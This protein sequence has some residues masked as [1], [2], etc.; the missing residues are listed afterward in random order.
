MAKTAT[1]LLNELANKDLVPGEV[2]ASLRAQVAKAARPVPPQQITKLLVEKGHLTAA[3]AQKLLGAA[4]ASASPKAATATATKPAPKA[5]PQPAPAAAATQPIADDLTALDGLEPLESLDSLEPLA[6]LDALDE[7]APAAAAPAPVSAESLDSLGDADL[8]GSVGGPDPLAA[9]AAASLQKPA[10]QKP[11]KPAAAP[12][13]P[14][15]TALLSL[16]G[17]ALLGVLAA[18]AFAFM[19]RANGDAEFQAAEGEYSAKSYAT[20]AEQYAVLLEKYPQHPQAGLARVH[21]GLAKMHAAAG[22]SNWPQLLPVAK[23]VLTEI[24]AQPQLAEAQAEVA[25]LVSNLAIGLAEQAAAGKTPEQIAAA[26]E[27]L[28]L[29]D[30]GRYVPGNHRP[31]QKLAAA[32]ESLAVAEYQLA[33]VGKLQKSLAA[34]K[35]AVTAKKL[36]EAQAVRE[37]LL[38][39]YPE[40]DRGPALSELG[41]E[42]AAAA[43]TAIQKAELPGQPEAAEGPAPTVALAAGT[44]PIFLAVAGGQLWALDAAKGTLRWRRPVGGFSGQPIRT[45]TEPDADVIVIDAAHSEVVRLA[46]ANGAPRWRRA[47]AGLLAAAPQIAGSQ[48]VLAAA[49]GRVLAL[50]AASGN[51]RAAVQLPVA[52]RAAPLVQ[53]GQLIV[54]G[55]SLY[56]FTLNVSDLSPQ[57]AAYLGHASASATVS[58]IALPQH[59]LVIENRGVG[60]AVLHVLDGAGNS[61]VQELAVGG[62]VTAPP[63]VIGS[64][65]VVPTGSGLTVFDIAA[66]AKTP[67]KKAA[68]HVI[69]STYVAERAGKLLVGGAGVQRCDLALSGR[70]LEVKSLWTAFPA[71]VCKSPPQA[72]SDAVFCVRC[73]PN[74]AAAIAAAVR[75]ANGQPLWETPLSLPEAAP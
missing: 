46:A 49:D 12:R 11:P 25:P 7:P 60:T 44:G 37:E 28:T 29:A 18:A 66:D 9:A 23:A 36:G 58:P 22:G 50:D 1:D 62:S 33:K 47:I 4:P 31:W 73:E 72:S 70:A 65:L 13:S 41:K 6:D 27:A 68:E 2:V 39:A 34:I 52:I 40:L 21:Q 19:P 63:A 14:M 17:V 45:G 15:A 8:L 43:L 30:N 75:S 53:G 69:A 24:E 57:S 59:K 3:Q 55:D 42:L 71:G 5:A 51:T 26:R 10:P 64:R 56:C 48:I 67:L 38:A 16:N 54:V 74:S 61:S 32:K 35:Q 20:A